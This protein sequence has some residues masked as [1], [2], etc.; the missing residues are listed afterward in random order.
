M[1]EKQI[2]HYITNVLIK[3]GDKALAK[4]RADAE[5]AVAVSEELL[6]KIVKDNKDTEY[7]KKY[8]FDEINSIDDYKRLVPFS[9]YDDYAPYIERMVDNNETNLISAYP[10]V[11]YAVSSG[12]VGVPKHI[13]VSQATI[14][15]YNTFGISRVLSSVN[16]YYMQKYGRPLPTGK[17]LNLME[18]RIQHTPNGVPKGA[19]SGAT[20][21]DGRKLLKYIFTPSDKI[22][23]PKEQMDMK[24]MKLRYALMEKDLVFITSAFMT[25]VVDL[26]NYM[27]DNWEVLCNDIE[28]GT[29]DENIL[30]SDEMR[31]EILT[32]LKPNKARAEELRK[33]FEEGFDTPIIPRIWPKMTW[34]AAVGTGG[35]ASYTE[36]MRG[37]AGDKIY[38][39][40]MVYAASESLMAAATGAEQTSFALLP[41]ACFYEFIPA[42]SEDE[43][44]TYNIGELEIGKNYEVVITNLSGFYRYKIKDV[45]KVCGFYHQTPLVEFVYRKNQMIS[46]AGEK[47]NDECFKYAIGELSKELGQTVLDYA[48]YADVE[49]NPGRYVILIEPVREI[50]M[51]KLNEYRDLLEE[52]LSFA[53][54]SYGSKI[55]EG[56]LAPMVLH[57][58][59]IET[60]AAYR[61][62]MIMKGTSE[63][64]IKPVRALDTPFKEG[65]FLTMV[66]EEI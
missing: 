60:H 38:F 61:D 35:F 12:S 19:I 3:R 8:H 25:A 34:I 1:F 13:P 7:G 6:M 14:N 46:I 40:F 18:V 33:I 52:K 65:F 17:G 39:E 49:S 11:H 44:T 28:N 29:I 21:N 31:A 56:I 23:F 20:I 37:F 27:R 4:L 51:S 64:Q 66:E 10:T 50:D 30:V 16:T 42:D 57:V 48:V 2:T 36:K 47:S 22:I 43:E 62:L 9:T 5:N 58:S 55:K 32:E 53:N 59:Q 63:N 26:M 24:Y 45:V 15:T 41:N 54:P